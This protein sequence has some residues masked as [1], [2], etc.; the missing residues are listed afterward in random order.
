MKIDRKDKVGKT[1]YIMTEKHRYK[2]VLL[3]LREIEPKTIPIKDVTEEKK[4]SMATGYKVPAGTGG[5]DRLLK[6]LEEA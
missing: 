2:E 4:G 5:M 1:V 6:V 3:L